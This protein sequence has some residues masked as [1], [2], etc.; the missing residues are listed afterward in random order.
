MNDASRDSRPRAQ[1]ERASDASGGAVLRLAGPWRLATLPAIEAEL[2]A[3]TLPARLAVDGSGLSD[4]DSAAALALLL[5]LP[6]GVQW[7][8]LAANDAR[9]IEQVRTRFANVPELPPHHRE[10]LLEGIGRRAHEVGRVAHGH[11][12][13]LGASVLGL[14]GSLLHPRRMRMRELSAQFEQV[15][16][17]AIPVVALV[18]LPDRRRHDLPAR[19]AG[20]EVR[21][22]H[23]RRRRRGIGV[24]ARVRADHRGD[25]RGRPLRRR[26]HRAAGHDAADRGD[27]RDPHARPVD[28]R[29]CWC[30][31]AC[32]R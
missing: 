15:G 8:G 23:L 29:R 32:W 4:L 18:T 25:H 7:T 17:N 30:C 31:R 24:D 12:A 2:G 14:I 1:L 26:V 16:L 10:R 3:L 22:Q 27:R 5:R 28:A 20:R 11:L 21:R 13:F 9:I 6:A 19:P